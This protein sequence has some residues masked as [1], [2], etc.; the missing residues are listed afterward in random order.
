MLAE[1]KQGL[2]NLASGGQAFA[3]GDKTSS[4]VMTPGHAHY[5]EPG[6]QKNIYIASLSSAGLAPGSTVGLTSAPP[7]ALWNPPGSGVNLSIIK[8]LVG[9]VSGTL[10]AGFIGYGFQTNVQSAP[11]GTALTAQGSFLGVLAN[12]GKAF[13]TLSA[14]STPTLLKPVYSIG[15]ATAALATFP[16]PCSDLVDGAIIVPQG[17]LFLMQ[18]NTAAGSSPLLTWGIEWEE[19]PV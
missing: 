19:I 2:F 3:R 7:I 14:M 17:G 5:T 16:T 11:T 12:M 18:G 13:Y 15:A 8:T 6:Y 1:L 10:G 9:Y 4:L